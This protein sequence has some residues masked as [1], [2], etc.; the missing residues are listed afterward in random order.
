LKAEE[1]RMVVWSKVAKAQ[2]ITRIEEEPARTI[3][4]TGYTCHRTEIQTEQEGCG[5]HSNRIEEKDRI[6]REK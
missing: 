1:E 3:N 5:I 6:S 4:V 2:E